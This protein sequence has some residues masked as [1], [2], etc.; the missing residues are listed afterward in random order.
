M[1][2]LDGWSTSAGRGPGATWRAAPCLSMRT[3]WTGSSRLMPPPTR[4]PSWWAIPRRTRRPMPGSTGCGASATGCRRRSATSRRPSA[5]RSRPGATPAARSRWRATGSAMSDSSAAAR[6][7]CR[8]SRRR[9]SR[10][11]PRPW[12]PS[13]AATT[14]PR[15][16]PR[17]CRRARV[18]T[19]RMTMAGRDPGKIRARLTPTL[20]A[21]QGRTGDE[22]GASLVPLSAP[23][24]RGGGRRHRRRRL[25]HRHRRYRHR[26]RPI[27][28]RQHRRCR[29]RAD[30]AAQRPGRRDRAGAPRGA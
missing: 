5:R 28:A 11:R 25:R 9:A 14:K 20:S 17:P 7:R 10:P 3:G 19:A 1:S 29:R 27:R 15:A 21:P 13:S 23:E 4:R 26:R 24:E 2:A 12:S 30:R 18:W 16:V 6:R 22:D 8:G